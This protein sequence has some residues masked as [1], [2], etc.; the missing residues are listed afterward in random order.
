[1]QA[2]S[3][4]NKLTIE[5]RY[6]PGTATNGQNSKTKDEGGKKYFM[7]NHIKYQISIPKMRVVKNKRNCCV[8]VW[9]AYVQTK[10]Q[11]QESKYV[12][13]NHL[14]GI[15]FCLLLKSHNLDYNGVSHHSENDIYLG[16]NTFA[17]KQYQA[18]SEFV[19]V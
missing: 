18:S 10:K 19:L 15:V 12:K 4:G 13:T 1:M 11:V 17:S 9:N 7:L 5:F 16:P 8:L 2:N 6:K 3:N 14:K